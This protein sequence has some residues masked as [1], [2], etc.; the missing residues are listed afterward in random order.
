MKLN[1]KQKICPNCK[2]ENTFICEEVEKQI[3]S[4]KAY[5]EIKNKPVYKCEHCGFCSYDFDMPLKEQTKKFIASQVYS[6]ILNYAQLEGLANLDIKIVECYNANHFECASL[7]YA[8]EQDF[9]KAFVTL[10]KAIQLKNVIKEEFY[11][12]MLADKEE[13][14]KTEIEQYERLDNLLETNIDKNFENLIEVFKNTEKNIYQKLL[15]IEACEIV[16]NLEKAQ[17]MYAQLIKEI[18]LPQDLTD[19][20]N[21][22]LN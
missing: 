7:V 14:S 17:Q 13:L 5:K 2:T 20:F 9:N 10:F 15:L 11:L 18:K 22:L 8:L 21:T 19:Y 16:G 12:Q 1:F 4:L 6:N 3:F